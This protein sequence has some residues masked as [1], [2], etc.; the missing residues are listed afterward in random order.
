MAGEDLGEAMVPDYALEP[1]L[2]DL[3]WRCAAYLERE[4]YGDLVGLV[5]AGAPAYDARRPSIGRGVADPAISRLQRSGAGSSCAEPPDLRV[6]ALL[7][8]LHDAATGEEI[9]AHPYPVTAECVS[10]AVTD[11]FSLRVPAS[12]RAAG[13][14]PPLITYEVRLDGG[15]PGRR[16]GRLVIEHA[17]ARWRFEPLPQ[18]ERVSALLMR[19]DAYGSYRAGTPIVFVTNDT[20]EAL[21]EHLLATPDAEA[22]VGLLGRI[23]SD[24][25][26]GL[27][28]TWIERAQPLTAGVTATAVSVTAGPDALLPVI[29]ENG[30]QL[31]G[32]AH[33]HPMAS[34][35]GADRITLS[36]VDHDT[37]RKRLR[38]AY[39][40]SL[41]VNI[42]RG[43]CAYAMFGWRPRSGDIGALSAFFVARPGESLRDAAP[44]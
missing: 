1:L 37:I 20:L 40:C 44:T 17:A 27:A 34:P 33:S 28:Y 14:T 6:A 43:C 25:Q 22:M 18:G 23:Y 2:S 11:L 5:R 32:L 30:L 38:R 39:M 26:S 21:T 29:N 3:H 42:S 4:A 10:G 31:C 9:V 13:E 36:T 16:A 24:P 12:S 41:I 8:T 35:Q 7:A 19:S 15:A